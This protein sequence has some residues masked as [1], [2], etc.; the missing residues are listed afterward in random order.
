MSAASESMPGRVF[1]VGVR[2]GVRMRLVFF[3]GGTWMGGGYNVPE[4]R[5]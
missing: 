2:A 1:S 4:L 3:G 5:L